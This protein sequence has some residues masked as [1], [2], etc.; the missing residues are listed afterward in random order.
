MGIINKGVLSKDGS[1]IKTIT[2]MD[3]KQKS[4]N[5]NFYNIY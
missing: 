2:I 3:V 4:D 1:L 5:H